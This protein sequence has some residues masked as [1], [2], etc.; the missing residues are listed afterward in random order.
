MPNR[1]VLFLALGCAGAVLAGCPKKGGSQEAKLGEQAELLQDYDS[2]LIHF[3]RAAKDDPSN[4]LYRLKSI[5][6]RALDGQYH[7]EQ[8]QK[9]R[10]QGDL[11][12]ALSEFQKA[13]SIDPSNEAATQ[14]GRRTM[15]MMSEKSAASAA[16][17]S[18][19][20]PPET[21]LL[22][23]PPELKPLS[24]API[25]FKA[26]NDV[27]FVFQTIGKIAGITRGV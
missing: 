13:A 15:E 8:G 16:L 6:L 19:P 4:T 20:A 10:K 9:Y 21:E 23:G 14:E 22:P 17:N 27:K 18:P 1:C 2:A 12:M 24:T 25:S 26:T 5:R 7:V 3:D 11:Q